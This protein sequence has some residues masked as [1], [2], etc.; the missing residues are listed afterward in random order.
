MLNDND[1]KPFITLSCVTTTLKAQE[2][3]DNIVKYKIQAHILGMLVKL[4][5]ISE[6][7]TPSPQM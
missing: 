4:Y 6:S 7:Q 2:I 5:V 1:N 3:V